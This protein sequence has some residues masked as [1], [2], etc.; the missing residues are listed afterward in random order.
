MADMRRRI[1]IINGGCDVVAFTR[2]VILVC[3]GHMSPLFI[4]YMP[5]SGKK[6][7]GAGVSPAPPCTATVLVSLCSS[8]HDSCANRGQ[9]HSAAS[10]RHAIGRGKHR[11]NKVERC[12][13]MRH[14]CCPL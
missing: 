5:S 10:H 6:E 14:G 4:Q 13:L 1:W 12:M 7:G 3:V 8:E 11:H 9:R 2:R